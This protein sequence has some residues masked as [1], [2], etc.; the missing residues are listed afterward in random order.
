MPTGL[1]L[2]FLVLLL[3]AIF[4]ALAVLALQILPKVSRLSLLVSQTSPASAEETFSHSR[5]ILIVRLGGRVELINETLRT[6]LGLSEKELPTLETLANRIWPTDEFL[7]LCAHEGERTLS[8]G[9]RPVEIVSFRIPGEE[10]HFLLILNR[11]ALPER[12]EEGKGDAAAPIKILSDFN[13]AVLTQTGLPATMRA[14]LETIERLVPVD[15]LTIKLWHEEQKQVTAYRLVSRPREGRSLERSEP[16]AAEDYTAVLIETGRPLYLA[17][18]QAA[19]DDALKAIALRSG[20]RSF[21]GLPLKVHRNLIGTLEASLT[22]AEAYSRE[23]FEVLQLISGPLAIAL[24][25]ALLLDR[26]ER[27]SKEMDGLTGLAR[28]VGEV[29]DWNDLFAKLVE[30]LAPLFDVRIFGFLILNEERHTL[31]AQV[32]FRGMPSQVVSLYRIP[33]TSGSAL[34][35]ALIKQELL[36]TRDAMTDE[37]WRLMGFQDYARAA[38][39]RDSA[40]V[41]LVC[42]DRLW[43]YLQIANHNHPESAFSAEE[44]RLLTI[45]A[46]Q[47]AT[48]IDDVSLYQQARRRTQRLETLRRI[49]NLAASSATSDEFLTYM[50][51]ELSRLLSADMVAVLLF[52][53]TSGLLRLHEKSV[54]GLDQEARSALKHLLV[55]ETQFPFTVTGSRHPILS[56]DLAEDQRLLP[57]YRPLHT[58]FGFRSALLV[59]L[60]AHQRSVGEVIIASK[61]AEHF[62][63]QDLQIV[64]AAASQAALHLERTLLASLTDA[65]LQRRVEQLTAMTRISREINTTTDL[66][67]LIRLV[68]DEL[69]RTTGADCGSLVLFDLEAEGTPLPKVVLRLGENSSTELL[70][71]EQEALR[72]GESLL[73]FDHEQEITY[74]PAHEGIRSSLVTPIAYQQSK[75]GLIHLHS[76]LPG[77]FDRSSLEI[78]EALAI[79]AAIAIGN[80]QRFRELQQRN[81]RLSQRT[82]TL[83][84][85]LETTSV[86]AS[87][88]PLEQALETVAYGIQESTPFEA[89]LISVIDQETMMQRRVCGVGMPIETLQLLKSHQQA[90]S[91]VAQLL[92]P[93]FRVGKGYFIPHDQRPIVSSDVQILTVMEDES[94][95]KLAPD[96]W[97]KDDVLL[98]PITD[99]DGNPIGLIS[100]DAPRDG[101]RPS[102]LTLET[103]EIFVA[104]AALIIQS[105][106]RIAAY[107]NQVERLTTSLERQRQLLAFSQGHLP[108]LLHKD[109]EQMIAIH[110][111]EQR[112]RRIR[113]GLEITE[114]V[115]RQVDVPSVLRALGREMLT[116]LEMSVSLVA[117][118]TLEGPRLLQ[119]AGNIP[120]GVNPEALFGQRNPLRHTLQTGETLLV[121]NLDQDDTWRDVSLLTSL[122]AKAFICLPVFLNNQ[123]VAGVLVMSNEPLPALTEEDRQVYEQISRQ[124]SI[125]LQDISLLTETRRRLREVNTL[126]EFSNELS[127]LDPDSML[128]VLLDNSLKVI[129][130]AHA[131]IVFLLDM[132]TGLLVPRI[133]RG[134]ADVESML[135]IT[136]AAG[137]SLPGRVLLERRPLRVDEVNFSRDYTLSAEG[138]LRYREATGGRLPVSSIVVP[139]QT[140]EHILGVLLLDNFNQTAAFT[141]DDETLLLSLAQQVALSLENARL[142][143]ASQERAAQL[144]ALTLASAAMAANL[145]T[146]DLIATLLDRLYNLLLFDTAILWLREEDRMRIVAARGFA[147]NEER[148]GLTV[149]IE[150]SLLLAEMKR[151]SQA[152][153]VGDVRRDPRFPTLLEAE[154]LSWLGVPLVSKG[155][156]IGV[157]VLEKTEANY[158]SEEL[159]QLANTFASQAAV[160]LENARLYE[161]SVRRAAELDERS[162]RLARL[163]LFSSSLSGVLDEMQILRLTA[164]ELQRALNAERIEMVSLEDP[165]VPVLRLIYS[166]TAEHEEREPLPPAPIFERLRESLGVFTTEDVSR[167]PD[168]APLADLL[169][170]TRSLLIIPLVSGLSL[171]ALAFVHLPAGERWS[172]EELELARTIANQAAIALE[173]AR[174][175]QATVQRAE[176][177][178]ILNR[179]SYEISATLEPEEIYRA[180]HRAAA[181]LMP[182]ESF[183]ITLLDEERNEIEGVYLVDP[184]G[185]APNQRIPLGQGLSSRILE[186]GEPILI[187]DA[188][189]QETGARAFG[190]GHSRSILAVPI[191]ISGKT[192]GM[193]SVQSYR[194]N[195]YDEEDLQVLSTLANQAAVAIQNGRLFAET[196]RLA[197]E[198]EQRVI[199]RTAELAREQRNTETLLRILTE[200]SS[201]LDLDRALNRTLALL[202]DAIGAEQGSILLVDEMTNTIHYRA[203]YGY[204]T[205]VMTEGGRP[206]SFKVG[207]GLVGWVIQN[208]QSVCL[209]DVTQDPRWKSMPFSS[210]SH[211]SVVAAPLLVGE[212]VIGAIMVFHRQVGYFSQE[213][214]NLVQAIGAQV[215]VAINNAKLYQLIRD[216]AERLGAMVRAEQVEASR[217]QAILEAVAD[218]VLVTNPENRITFL[219]PSAERILRLRASKVV[220]QPLDQFVG[221]F[222]SAARTWMTTIRAWSEDPSSYQPG[223]TYAEQIKLDDGRVVLVHLSPVIWRNDFL[224][225]VSIFRDITREVEVDRLKSEFVAT[226]SHELRTPMTSIKG[227]VDLLLMGAAGA[228]NE[229]QIHFLEVVRSNTDRLSVL[230]NDLLDISRIEAG[231]VTLTFQPV[232][233]RALAEDTVDELLRRSQ[234]ESK[235][236]AIMLD[237]PPDL[238]P[239]HGDPERIRQIF[240]N[241]TDN[242]YNYTPAGGEI[243]IT[244]Q[245]VNDMLQVAVRDNG[246]G[247]PPE[248]LHRVFERFYRGEDALVLATPGTGLGLSIVEQ[249]VKMHHGEIWAE[250]E[251]IPGRGST[252]YFTLPIYRPEE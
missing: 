207:E 122:H 157:I 200:A 58:K 183:V 206:T 161:E 29:R 250:S 117:E 162:R 3:G 143:Q 132:S 154:R 88:L 210:E 215:A 103:I 201:T 116:R 136:Y 32:P 145:R 173:G 49:T 100:L 252:F 124:V 9:G 169:A 168:L 76:F 89:V 99:A 230:V 23:D 177:M 235:P 44:I 156:L 212:E 182:V 238:P 208:R 130:T 65:S 120:R 98:F 14:A 159:V 246:I 66:N 10:P 175:Y 30:T 55:T 158:F 86:L 114:M 77:H 63:V 119:V 191:K 134:Y 135:Q 165:N 57:L 25:N 60:A 249:L 170:D 216:Q 35:E 229:N 53:E 12:M 227:Y 226:V 231:R 205:P 56:H 31:E 234:E 102:R 113:A 185:R 95:A 38:S 129:T 11:L 37:R 194:P 101:K 118:N 166:R 108:A 203:G 144:Q 115:T 248:N 232:D 140:G 125:I 106:Q 16:Q 172:A 204:L 137:E 52:E 187:A 155:D 171:R 128:K 149:N 243:E 141:R 6:W 186:T 224:G 79:Q 197:D 213:H 150:D 112:A 46:A 105:K 26:Q 218:G 138:L 110:R 75:A 181:Q 107:R 126:L 139:I 163:N 109:L 198:L 193:L 8:L 184:D 133:A 34:E 7:Y 20:V 240:A 242:A 222:G 111:L 127:T 97:H 24:R 18:A 217:Q 48:L 59:P 214:V 199:E 64:S 202:N 92:R 178:A 247:I 180:I 1:P 33:L 93:E 80:A 22:G 42:A 36:I 167:E 68:Y 39:I 245:V 176:Q 83:S 51:Q 179:A 195:V 2:G 148:V 5:G 209:P 19:R 81:E 43:G 131:G 192:I 225:T 228:L 251:G 223:E 73:V 17:D 71:I 220:G 104:Q 69:L 239:A 28:L 236:M 15:N 211:R 72:R 241:L 45:V 40:L 244:I 90:W 189:A 62:S 219:N 91:S 142:M 221:L 233:L 164:A 87:D 196:R 78:A 237:A 96:A 188:A 151:T 160:A 85:L 152:I 121:M 41:P 54:I 82:Q 27:Q 74:P 174:L 67:Y 123:V 94:K 153:V 70:P 50:T 47:A 4:L 13:Q 84:K 190:R 147:D 146:S 21:I 61:K